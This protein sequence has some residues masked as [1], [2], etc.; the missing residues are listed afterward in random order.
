MA[1]YLGIDYGER[2]IGIAISDPSLTI[3]QPFTTITWQS[4]KDL[5]NKLREIVQEYDVERVVIGLPLT[6]G[7]RNSQKTV[8]VRNFVEK[9]TKI[10]SVPIVFQDE[11]LTTKQAYLTMRQGGKKPS[12]NKEKVDQLAAQ[13]ILQSYLD[14]EKNLDK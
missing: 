14:R 13:F 3:A 10:I 6:M 8:E 7:G 4:K 11:R 9:L 1:R 5:M 12:R 2:R